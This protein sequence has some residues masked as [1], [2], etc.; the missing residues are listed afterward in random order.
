M[1]YQDLI[2]EMN[3][4]Y[5]LHKKV[6]TKCLKLAII[7]YSVVTKEELWIKKHRNGGE[8]NGYY[9]RQTL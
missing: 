1:K 8:S 3:K 6:L 7:N 4:Y 5:D 2:Q 9:T